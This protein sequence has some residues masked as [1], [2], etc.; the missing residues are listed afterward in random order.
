MKE[1]YCV[2]W[3]NTKRVTGKVSSEVEA[4]KYCYGI[5]TPDMI[6]VNLGPRKD[7]VNKIIMKTDSPDEM[8]KLAMKK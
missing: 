5:S 1:Y 2:F 6:A 4:K 8:L 7:V 3:G